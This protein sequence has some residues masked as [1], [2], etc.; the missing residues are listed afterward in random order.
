MKSFASKA[1]VY[2]YRRFS[3][4]EQEKG[5]SIAR[6]EKYAQKIAEKYGLEINKD[7]VMTDRGLS[8]FHAE[9]KKKGALGVFLK[10]VEEEKVQQGSV[11]IVESLDRLS[12]EQPFKAQATMY[13]IIEAGITII[14]AKDSNV[15]NKESIAKNPVQTMIL[16]ILESIRAHSESL[17]K[18]GYSINFLHDQITNHLN[19]EVSDVAGQVPFWISRKPSLHK[20]IKGG[21]ELNEKSEIAKEIIQLYKNGD[22]VR[23]ISRAL[24]AKNIKAPKGGDSWGVSTLSSILSNPSLCGKKVFEIKY[25]HEGKEVIEPYN[26]DKYYPAIMSE[27]EFYDL[28]AIKKR[29]DGAGRGDRGQNVHLLSD[30]GKRSVCSECGK[31]VTT[32]TQKQKYRSRRRLHCSK[33]KDTEDCCKSI[34]QDY[35]EDAFLVSVARHIDHNLINQDDDSSAQISVEERLAEVKLA[36]KNIR[37]MSYGIDDAEEMADMMADYN[38]FKAEKELLQNKNSELKQYQVSQDEIKGFIERVE[39]ARV[40]EN[41]EDRKFIKSILEL[42]IRKITVHMQAKPLADYGY[43]NLYENTLVNVIDVEFY[44]DRKLSVFVSSAK[45]DSALLF[46]KI[47]DEFADDARGSYTEAQLKVWNDLGFEALLEELG[48]EQSEHIADSAWLTVDLAE[49]LAAAFVEK[50]V[51]DD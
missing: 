48:I 25:L 5:T 9:H 31:S 24:R 29:R 34:V 10:L 41:T 13:E 14:T 18:Q 40:F 19:G 28:Q 16:S 26:L 35:I 36:M 38:Q 47:D 11:L 37:K 46:T 23:K 8:A 32:Q 6:Q 27:E 51:E 44:S 15:F 49:A 3:N 33:Y 2:S 20:K 45:D 42:C 39:A 43:E 7:L 50:M 22:G 4:I 30:Y 12:R 1:Q 21:F 17:T